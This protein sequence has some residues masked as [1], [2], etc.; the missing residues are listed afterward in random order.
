MLLVQRRFPDSWKIITY[1]TIL[2]PLHSECKKSPQE[3]SLLVVNTTTGISS[4]FLKIICA[5]SEGQYYDGLKRSSVK[6]S[7]LW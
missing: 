5:C 3:I 6:E 2:T 7:P 1:R 4:T